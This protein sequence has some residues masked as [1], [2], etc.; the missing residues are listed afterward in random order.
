MLI[1][2]L[3]QSLSD[4]ITNSSSE[5]FVVK[6]VENV[7]ELKKI[8]EEVGENNR[9]KGSWED[10]DKLSPE[11]QKKYDEGSGMGGELTV[12]S[13]KEVYEAYKDC[14]P[15]SKQSQYTPEIW[16]LNFEESLEE[17]KHQVWIDIDHSRNAT[18]NWI[19]ENLLVHSAD[20]YFRIDPNTGRYL[21]KVSW[22]E[23]LKLPEN[24]RNSY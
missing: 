19:L 15:E 4:V 5:I 22:E 24:E 18:I 2:V 7:P 20:G 21:E 17:L 12:K 1:R 11:E 8:V 23:W 16:S 9:F 3:I 6:Q 13:W 10:W 14:V